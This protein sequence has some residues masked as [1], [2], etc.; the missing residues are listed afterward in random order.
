M[1]PSQIHK[2][3]IFY[4]IIEE[5]K[6]LAQSAD[7]SRLHRAMRELGSTSSTV[8]RADRLREYT[9][10]IESCV[11]K[12]MSLDEASLKAAARKVGANSRKNLAKHERIQLM[13]EEIRK[14]WIVRLDRM[15][16][17]QDKARKEQV[18]IQERLLKAAEKRRVRTAAIN[19]KVD[20]EAL[21]KEQLL[22]C[23]EEYDLLTEKTWSSEFSE[24]QQFS[25]CENASSKPKL[26]KL[27]S[28]GAKSATDVGSEAETR[29][30]ATEDRTTCSE[31]EIVS[32][33][34]KNA[35]NGRFGANSPKKVVFEEKTPLEGSNLG[36]VA[37]TV[38]QIDRDTSSGNLQGFI[39]AP[40][41]FWDSGEK[42]E[43]PF[44]L[45]I[46]VFRAY[47]DNAGADEWPEQSKA[48][49][50]KISLG[51]R[52]YAL[53]VSIPGERLRWKR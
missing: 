6:T 28:V 8:T 14:T 48:N 15:V 38:S 45:W 20:E 53:L 5:I 29:S 1:A 39:S 30:Q 25:E 7:S 9:S 41:K 35:K 2:S 40:A 52:G 43:H 23:Q 31:F 22:K 51:L 4:E 27:D 50:F 16:D 32:S 36:P 3:S 44:R 24:K 21:K 18:K 34:P 47:L 12:W 33:E 26:V 13:F 37:R 49:L 19:E 17:E 46:D 42:P 11:S 10:M